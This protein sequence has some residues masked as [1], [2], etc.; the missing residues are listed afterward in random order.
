MGY[1]QSLTHSN[2]FTKSDQTDQVYNTCPQQEY[3]AHRSKPLLNLQQTKKP[4]RVHCV[5]QEHPCRNPQQVTI[6]QNPLY[7]PETP[8][9]SLQ[10][11]TTEP[12][13]EQETTQKPIVCSKNSLIETYSKSQLYRIYCITKKRLTLLLAVGKPP[14][15]THYTMNYTPVIQELSSSFNTIERFTQKSTNMSHSIQQI[16]NVRRNRY[17]VL[18]MRSDQ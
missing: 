8:H 17:R 3:T 13:A 15:Q 4:H 18:R 1:V 10:Q 5:F 14:V 9:C 11:T 12:T 2:D 7:N 6:I 16:R